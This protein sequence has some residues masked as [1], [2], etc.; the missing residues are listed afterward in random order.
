MVCNSPFR[1]VVWDWNSEDSGN[2]I[3]LEYLNWRN[4][5]TCQTAENLQPRE[6][7]IARKFLDYKKCSQGQDLNFSFSDFDS[8]MNVH[9]LRSSM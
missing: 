9:R 4:W 1:I 8:V 7:G 3:Q 5:N 2:D 6:C